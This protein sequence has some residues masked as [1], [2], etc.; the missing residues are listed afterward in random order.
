[1]ID[2]IDYYHGA[3]IVRLIEDSRCRGISKSE[4]GYVVNDDIL[5]YLKYSTKGHSPWHFTITADDMSRLARAGGTLKKCVIGLVCGGDGVCAAPWDSV[6]QLI[7]A[8]PAWSAAK[9]T[10]NGSPSLSGSQGTPSCKIAANRL[11]LRA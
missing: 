9:R 8:L 6:T 3:A 1:M 5:L 7:A 11:P 10:L 2:R 4:C